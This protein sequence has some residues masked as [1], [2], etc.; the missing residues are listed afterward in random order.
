MKKNK[1]I[2]LCVGLTFASIALSSCGQTQGTESAQT[3]NADTSQASAD[4]QNQSFDN[5]K[6]QPV[7]FIDLTDENLEALSTQLGISVDAI[8]SVKEQSQADRQPPQDGQQPN[9][10]PP[11][12]G[13]QPPQGERPDGQPPQGGMQFDSETVVPLFEEDLASYAELTSKTEE[14]LL[15]IFQQ[16]EVQ[17]S[18]QN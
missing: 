18:Q 7:M 3:Q 6:M 1:I 5:K 2:A 17:V 11:T 14:E 12:D 4:G 15:T 8:K 10:Q 13:Q 9:G 16:Y